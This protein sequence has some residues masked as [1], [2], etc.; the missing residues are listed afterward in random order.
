MNHDAPRDVYQAAYDEAAFELRKIHTE[1]E[2][3]SLRKEQV[4]K[5]IAVL[6]PETPFDGFTSTGSMSLTTKR[7]GMTAVTRLTVMEKNFSIKG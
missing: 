7:A 1:F 4:A 3:L 2:R 5:V 6:K